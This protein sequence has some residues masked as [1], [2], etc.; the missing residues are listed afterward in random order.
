MPRFEDELTL[1]EADLLKQ[2]RQFH[3]GDLQKLIVDLTH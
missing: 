3:P 2:A 1:M